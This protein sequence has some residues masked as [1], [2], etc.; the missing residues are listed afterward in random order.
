[1]QTIVEQDIEH[2]HLPDYSIRLDDEHVLFSNR[3]TMRSRNESAQGALVFLR[4]ETYEDAREA[5]PGWDVHYLEQ[6]WRAW[7]KQA[8][9]NA[10]RAFVGFCKKWFRRRGRPS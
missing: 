10:D 9:R 2:A 3:G 7:M 1:M 4:Q 5:A 6:E 8:P